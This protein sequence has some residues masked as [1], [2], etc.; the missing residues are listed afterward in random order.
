[1]KHL[2]SQKK[3]PQWIYPF[4]IILECLIF[5]IGNPLTKIGMNYIPTFFYIA[6]RFSAAFLFLFAVFHKTVLAH[7]KKKYWMPCLLISLFNT[8]AFF[9]NIMAYEHA[10]ATSVGFLISLPSLFTP[11]LAFFISRRPV[12]PVHLVPI[13]IM[14]LGMYYFCSGDGG[15]SL[16]TGELLALLSSFTYAVTFE[17]CVKYLEDIHPVVVTVIQTGF[18]AVAGIFIALFIGEMPVFSAVP[19]HAWMIVLYLAIGSTGIAIMLQNKALSGL[20]STQ[21]ALLLCSEPVFTAF[22]AGI[23]LQERL[24]PYGWIGAFLIMASLI[25]SCLIPQKKKE[26]QAAEGK[27]SHS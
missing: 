27:L 20:T 12:R 4:Y 2:T 8:M 18:A 15:F 7:M 10:S 13:G 9:F 19:F 23:F 22:F 11:F 3:K 16:G 1:M 17:L 14:M 24:T 6:V 21:G 5:G 26:Q 25:L